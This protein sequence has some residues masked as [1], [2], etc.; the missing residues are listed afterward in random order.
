MSTHA[1]HT[2]R[3]PVTLHFW[4]LFNILLILINTGHARQHIAIADVDNQV[5][6]LNN[7]YGS[8]RDYDQLPPDYAVQGPDG[9]V[10]I[11]MQN[12]NQPFKYMHP[13][14][15]TGGSRA[16]A[17]AY[18]ASRALWGNVGIFMTSLITSAVPVGSALNVL[19]LGRIG[20]LGAAR[21]STSAIKGFT[22]HATNQAVTRGFKSADILKIVREGK[23]V[24]AAGRYGSQ[25][26]YTLGGNT[27]VLNAQGK[28]VTVFSNAPGTANGLG[29]GFFMPFK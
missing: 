18:N 11:L 7:Q 13:V 16:F 22:K 29:K 25:T 6:F 2:E 9:S 4:W 10:D 8:V 3:C 28:V 21:G 23:A 19:K 20:K 1:Q 5:T 17:N 15:I 26:R 27:V 12:Y 24:Q 14:E